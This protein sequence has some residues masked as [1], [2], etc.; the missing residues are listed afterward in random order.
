[1]SNIVFVLINTAIL[2]KA[3]IIKK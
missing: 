3:E 1:M 2:T